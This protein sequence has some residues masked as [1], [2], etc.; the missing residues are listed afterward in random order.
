MP[1]WFLSKNADARS[2]SDSVSAAPLTPPDAAGYDQREMALWAVAC[3]L[4]SVFVFGIATL[5]YYRSVLQNSTGGGGT[6][7][8][9]D[10]ILGTASQ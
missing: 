7:G 4:F 2:V 10:S 8:Q 3:A 5:Q 1:Y 6:S 9:Y